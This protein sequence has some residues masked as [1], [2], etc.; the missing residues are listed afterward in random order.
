[1]SEADAEF[2]RLAREYL[3]DRADGTRIP[4]PGLVT[5]GSTQSCPT[6]RR[7]PGPTSAARLTAGPPG[8]PRS[9]AAPCRR[10]TRWTPR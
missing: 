10:S 6:R 8:S 9:T 5:T 3:D 4:P 2:A 7:R 1:M